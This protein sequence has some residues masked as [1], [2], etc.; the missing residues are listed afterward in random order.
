MDGPAP[1]PGT[2]TVLSTPD[3]SLPA[4]PNNGGITLTN[5]LCLFYNATSITF[6]YA[7]NHQ[8]VIAKGNVF[9]NFLNLFSVGTNVS[10]DIGP[11]IYT[12]I[13]QFVHG[14]QFALGLVI[15]NAGNVI[16][17][18]YLYT[19]N[20]LIAGATPAGPLGG[21]GLGDTTVGTASAGKAS[22]P[23]APSGFLEINI[24]GSIKKIP[25]YEP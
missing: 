10:A 7:G 9:Q 13:T 2:Y 25:Y 17:Y 11:N 22:L 5:N 1:D 21:I 20:V 18:P 6:L 15:D 16:A 23:S 8:V 24:N 3:L 12:G 14:N 4:D 19:P